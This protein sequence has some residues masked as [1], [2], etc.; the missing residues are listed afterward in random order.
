ME[1]PTLLLFFFL[2]A[3]VSVIGVSAERAHELI[4]ELKGRIDKILAPRIEERRSSAEGVIEKL[5]RKAKEIEALEHTIALKNETIKNLNGDIAKLTFDYAKEVAE[6]NGTN[7][8][9]KP[10]PI[11]GEWVE[12]PEQVDKVCG[13]CG[14]RGRYRKPY[15]D[16]LSDCDVCGEKGELEKSMDRY[17]RAINVLKSVRHNLRV[18][19][20]DMRTTEELKERVASCIAEYNKTK[21]KGMS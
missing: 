6:R 5:N 19:G 21:P 15:T 18:G 9:L 20:Q 8:T 17:L 12:A 13:T 10:T 4:K 2:L 7:G 11:R 16:Y 14:G 3:I 1:T